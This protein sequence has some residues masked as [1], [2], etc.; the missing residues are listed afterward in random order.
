M[1]SERLVSLMNRHSHL[2]KRTV[3]VEDSNS[4][5]HFSSS[6]DY[7]FIPLVAPRSKTLHCPIC[8]FLSIR[9]YVS[10]R[11][12]QNFVISDHSGNLEVGDSAFFF[13]LERERHFLFFA[14]FGVTLSSDSSSSAII[15]ETLLACAC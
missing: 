12:K 9:W 15:P 4:G 1:P 6:L 3:S 5:G 14:G 8:I 11:H 2:D 13:F 7:F 10:F